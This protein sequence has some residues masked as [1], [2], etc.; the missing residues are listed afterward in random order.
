MYVATGLR[1]SGVFQ[2]C[3]RYVLNLLEVCFDSARE[4]FGPSLK[5][6]LTVLKVSFDLELCFNKA[7]GMF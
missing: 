3:S 5:Y 4:K 7:P 6:V 1:Y 2:L